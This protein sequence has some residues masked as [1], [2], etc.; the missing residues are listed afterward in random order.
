MKFQR[1]GD[2][3]NVP[4]ILERQLK[5]VEESIVFNF[6]VIGENC[7]IH[8]RDNG[9]YKD[10]TGN[11]RN[12]IGYVIAYEGEILE[13]G[14]KYSSGISN[15]GEFLAKYKINEMLTGDTGYS[16]V[17]VAGMSY[18]RKVENRGKNVLSATEGYLK[19][20]VRTKMKRILSKAGFK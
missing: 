12:S 19:K 6:L 15:K 14:F 16:L 8:A 11:L 18:A 2:W 5:R 7:V 20:E 3:K 10:Q 1:T 17:I 4:L 13:W 9:K